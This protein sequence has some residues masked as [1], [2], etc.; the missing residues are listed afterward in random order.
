MTTAAKETYSSTYKSGISAIH[1]IYITYQ[2]QGVNIQIMVSV[3]WCVRLT[4]CQFY[5]NFHEL[6]EPYVA[7][8]FWIGGSR[9]EI[10]VKFYIWMQPFSTLF[11]RKGRKIGSIYLRFS[12]QLHSVR[13]S[14]GYSQCFAWGN[15]T[16]CFFAFDWSEFH[17]HSCKFVVF[18]G[19]HE[20]RSTTLNTSTTH[21]D[22]QVEDRS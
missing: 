5:H 11:M 12:F 15:W 1:Q 6:W 9:L 13:L 8:D 21:T 10:I 16:I 2:L 18:I 19:T 3:K 7:Q 14:Q 22:L 17:V 20:D 4:I